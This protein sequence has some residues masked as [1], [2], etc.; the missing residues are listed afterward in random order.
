MWNSPLGRALRHSQVPITVDIADEP[1][2]DTDQYDEKVLDPMT[3]E[4]MVERAQEAGVMSSYDAWLVRELSR[5]ET[6]ATLVAAPET[7]REFKTD[8]VSNKMLEEHMIRLGERTRTFA[9]SLAG[10]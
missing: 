10:G 6:I 3:F 1:V 2:K 7:R 4:R 5:G 8:K 9:Q